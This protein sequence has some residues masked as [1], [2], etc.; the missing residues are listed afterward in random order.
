[1]SSSIKRTAYAISG[2][3]ILR[4]DSHSGSNIPEADA[5]GHTYA[6]T[7]VD[8]QTAALAFMNQVGPNRI[9]QVVHEKGRLLD[10]PEPVLKRIVVY[11]TGPVP[12]F[13]HLKSLSHGDLIERE[14][15]LFNAKEEAAENERAGRSPQT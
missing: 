6:G 14:R 4:N 2:Q 11:Y 12:P 10:T 5:E 3:R 9:L 13:N 7:P 15:L 1:M 8:L